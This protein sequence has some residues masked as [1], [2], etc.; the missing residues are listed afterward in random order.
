MNLTKKIKTEVLEVYDTWLHSYLN[1]DVKTYDSFLDEEYHFIG[2]TGNEEFLNRKASTKFFKDT[3]DQLA[4]K[5]DIK[6]K[7]RT[8][9]YFDG[10]VFITEIFDAYFMIKKEWAY[11]GRFRFTSVLRNKA[12]GWRFIYQHFSMPDSKA[13]NGETLG[14]EQVSKEN[15][16]LKDA[17]KRGTAELQIKNRELEIEAALERVRSKAMAMHSSEDLATTADAFFS[18]LSG[19]TV[20][21][22]RCGMG[23]ID[24]KTRIVDVYST[25]NNDKNE[26]KKINAQL[27]LAGHPILDKIFE[28]WQL[29]N[30]YFPVLRGKEIS[31]YYNAMNPEVVF[32]AFA[33]DEVQYGYY[34]FFKE[35][36]IYVWTDTELKEKDLQIFRRYNSVLSLTLRRY[37]DIKEAEAQARE[38]QI[39]AALEKVRSRSLAMRKP[40]ELQ[41]V[42]AVVAEKLQ[43][44]DVIIDAGGVIICTYFPGN[45]DV[46]HWI[47]ETDFSNSG[48][49]LIPYF[50]DLTFNESWDSKES[51][52]AFFTKTYYKEEK[53]NFFN[54]AFEHT[55]Y[56]NFPDDFKQFV[57]KSKKMVLSFAWAKNSAIMLPSHTGIVPS[58]N[59]IEIL[60]RFAK[61]FE[62]AYTRFLDLKKA[63]AQAKEAQIEL[64]LERI[65]AQV[66]SMKES[67]DLLDIVVTMRSEF[68]ALGHEAHYFWYMRWLPE[69]YEK[70]M[71]SGDGTKIGMI[72]SLPRHIHGDIKLVDDWEKSNEPALVFAMDVETAVDYINKMI[73]LGDFVQ[74]DPSAPTLDD[75]RHIGGLT[76]IMARTKHGE[77]GYSLPGVVPNPPQE[78]LDTLVRFAGVFDL[79]YR[80]FEDLKAAELRNRETQIELALE[81][82]RNQSMLMKHS[83][84]LNQTSRVFHEQLEILGIESEFSYLWLP[85]EDKMEHLF[86][87][88]WHENKKGIIV[89]KNKEVIYPL[90]KTEPSIAACYVAWESGEHV[91]LNPV[92]P[93][94]VEDYFATWDE[95][96]HEVDKFKPELF[97]DGIYYVDAYMKYGCFGIMIK[98]EI[99]GDEKKILGR[100][101][102]EFERAYTRF[103]D[104]KKSEIQTREAKIETALERV[105]ARAMAMQ[106]PEE[107]K[108]VA[109]VL[110]HEMGL[111]GVEE[112]ETCSIY[113]NDKKKEQAECWYALKDIR[114]TKKK[115]VSDHFALNMN[116][117]SVGR[118][119]LK[120]YK[121][122]S[123]QVSIVMTGKPRSEWIRY[124]EEKSVPLGGYYGEVIPDRTYHLYKF[125][126][127]AI[128]AATPGGFS[129]ENWGLLRKAASVFSMAYSR[130]NDLTKARY[131]L[132]QLKE[133]KKRAENALTELRATQ[134]QLI[135]AE[136]MASLGELTAG[137]AHEIQNPLN[138]VNNFAEVSVDL[139]EE[140][141][142]EFG[143]G[144][145][146][147]VKDIANDLKQ[148][149][150]KI[151]NH[152]Q[153]ASSIV[154]GM[155]EHSRSGDGKKELTDINL[156]AD[157]YLR[158]A[159]HGLR[160]KDKSFNAD[161]KTEFDKKLP[162]ARVIPQDIGRVLLNLINNAFYA[163]SVK[164]RH[165][166]SQQEDKPLV[167]LTT[168]NLGDSIEI[169][170]KDNGNGIPA[171]IKEKIFQPFFTTKPTGEG[172]GLGLSMS[173]DIITKGHG[174]KL[175]VETK[176]GEGT[177]F[178]I[179][180]PILK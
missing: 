29:Q 175:E 149:L 138:F 106:Q 56:K 81:R 161:F 53:N 110:R 77:I 123:N 145:T 26:T 82:S 58:E 101:A 18:E 15:R 133:E 174:G 72:M 148:N 105:R 142:E 14:A 27:T 4:G 112:L 24:S 144:N 54:Y 48:K 49:Y 88:T 171:D 169:S 89:Y 108:E 42:V 160:A 107:L 5:T 7:I 119:M 73:T 117:T 87:A 91:H 124:C 118:E 109:E 85:D 23:I 17:I 22:H 156:L 67:T 172:T 90:D 153:R 33:E 120:F 32:P 2:S 70:A 50:D 76:F 128:G 178:L 134:S 164:T 84:E 12:Q 152:G 143:L 137:I 104:L 40:E 176:E 43:E 80:R 94:E 146:E 122:K 173:Y 126:H 9:E 25:S 102:V 132:Q 135:H 147:E 139:L 8:I 41:E 150:N 38:A 46:I 1:G 130:F 165:A 114:N 179:N 47:A 86:H 64:S 111:L 100:F 52:E 45:K 55:G 155:L 129:E 44:L 61:V 167:T 13:E 170:V 74:V 57:L 21:P 36:G 51:G 66:T 125:S 39:E 37:F 158:L 180:I 62:Q 166:L 6:N 162:K 69:K 93:S 16:E 95:L 159:Y 99:S 65:R 115:L 103:L 75:I 28:N 151:H 60:K 78:S 79:A 168:K 121:S 97:P 59:H 10:L 71:T 116:D 20:T 35:C 98:R 92:A 127:G 68:M 157:E 63:E 3:A 83:D 154:K 136:K 177:T 11:Y 31:K 141:D 30:E 34:F 96:L 140:M 113:I 163:A 131:D 19:L